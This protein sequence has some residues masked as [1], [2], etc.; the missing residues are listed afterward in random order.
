M[1]YIMSK[2]MVSQENSLKVKEL[3]TYSQIH[4][5]KEYEIRQSSK[6]L[7]WFIFKDDI[8]LQGDKG[9]GDPYNSL[10]QA[11]RSIHPERKA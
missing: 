1:E 2:R 7:R 8:N 5:F 4:F 6:S 9:F 11:K 3:M 10:E